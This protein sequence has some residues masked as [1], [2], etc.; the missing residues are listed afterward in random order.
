[1]PNGTDSSCAAAARRGRGLTRALRGSVRDDTGLLLAA[2]ACMPGVAAVSLPETA[3]Q[4]R[5]QARHM[6][7]QPGCKARV[8]AG[9][10][11]RDEAPR[12]LPAA[13]RAEGFGLDLRAT[14]PHH[15]LQ[16]FMKMLVEGAVADDDVGL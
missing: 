1:M 3:G 14:A 15:Q 7:G 12:H 5:Q 13:H 10:V 6:A 4:C 2:V 11:V 8:Q 16:P 9:E